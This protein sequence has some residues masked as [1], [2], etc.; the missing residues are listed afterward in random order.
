MRKLLLSISMLFVG[1]TFSM[2]STLFEDAFNSESS[3]SNWDIVTGTWKVEG[4][5]L[6]GKGAG[7]SIDGWIYAGDTNWGDYAFETTAHLLNGNA[8]IVFRST[9]HWINEYRLTLF[10]E[11]GPT[12][13]NTFALGKYLNGK[14]SAISN[15]NESSPVPITGT[16]NVK[17]VSVGDNLQGFINDQKIFE[18]VDNE[19]LRNG[20]IGLGVIWNLE[21]TFDNVV[22]SDLK[23][24]VVPE[25]ASMLLFGVG[26]LAMV[27]IRNKKKFS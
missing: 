22:V 1:T 10:S 20:R 26:G 3:L 24:N 18:Y 15:G 11:F 6:H 27:F 17:V 12:Y 13:S 19:P 4:G 2:A 23:P 14:G 25:P 9:G 21:N 16:V 8:D 5:E 7:Q